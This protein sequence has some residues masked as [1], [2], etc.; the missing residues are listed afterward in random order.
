MKTFGPSFICCL[1]LL[2]ASG[3][4]HWEFVKSVLK[5]HQD[6]CV[7]TTAF[8]RDNYAYKY[9][10]E[11]LV[12]EFYCNE[13]GMRAT[14][15]PP[16][17]TVLQAVSAI[18]SR[19]STGVEGQLQRI[20]DKLSTFMSDTL[21]SIRAIGS[22]INSPPG[23]Q[24]NGWSQFSTRNQA[25]I[26][27]N[28]VMKAVKPMDLWALWYYGDAA[29]NIK[30]YRLISSDE[31]EDKNTKTQLTRARKVVQCLEDIAVLKGYISNKQRILSLE[32][33]DSIDIFHKSFETLVRSDIQP[34][35]ATTI[36]KNKRPLEL[37]FCSIYDKYVKKG[38]HDDV[39]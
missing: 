38:R 17:S 23:Q 16:L 2:L 26:P 21:N 18:A 33:I 27:S 13:T 1:P 9:L 14:G 35:L 36:T 25:S 29:R 22:R 19:P 8:S 10:P 6:H 32:Y 28:F 11:V 5:D 4:Y 37:S 7:F 31:I 24:S 34:P 39:L 30:P 20:D 15:V 12:G 3:V